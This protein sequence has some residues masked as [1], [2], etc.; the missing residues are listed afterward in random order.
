MTT[1]I[2][3]NNH[4]M[5]GTLFFRL[6]PIQ[7]LIFAMSSV[8]SIIDGAV[9]GQFIDATTVGVVGLYFPMV[10]VLTAVGNVLLGGTSV[11]C[12]R[13]MG[14]GDLK[15]TKGI[16]S[17]N[18]FLT[19]SIGLFLTLL[20]LLIPGGL[21]NMLGAS[22]Q[23]K[24]ALILYITGYAFGIVP[25]LLAQQLASFLQLERQNKRSYIG[26]GAMIISNTI[27][28]IVLVAYL[29]MGIFGLA[30]ATTASNWIYCLVLGQYYL[31]KKAQLRFDRKLIDFKEV[32]P[33]LAIGIPGA[34]L[35]VCLA[36]RSLVINRLL[37]AYAGHDGL[38]AMS[39]YNMVSGLFIAYCL[40]VGAVVRMLTSIFIGEGDRYSIKHLM[41]IVFTQGLFV[42]ILIAIVIVLCSG[43]ITQIFFPDT[44]SNVYAITKQLVIIYGSVIPIILIC[45]VFTNYLQAHEHNI[46]VNILSIFDGFLSMVIPAVL[47]A[48]VLGVLGIW[49]AG[50]IGIVMTALLTPLY[51]IYY[52]KR[53]PRNIDE[54]LFF[55]PDF[56]AKEEDRLDVRITTLEEVTNTARQVQDFCD[57][58][59]LSPKLSYYAALC[60]EEMAANVVDHGFHKDDKPHVVDA[61]VVY[62]EKS[63]LLRIKDD[64]IPFN[65]QERA[66]L[67]QSDDPLKNIGIRMVLKLADEVSYHNLL[68]LN[69]STLVLKEK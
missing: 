69:V 7:V 58:H 39:A 4:D 66:N 57:K 37:I 10:N 51:C 21:A 12:G 27:A 19:I 50:P 68:G 17:L 5:I 64:C 33:L 11:L 41:K 6:L 23:L 15:R 47:L 8:N 28:D 25:Q 60:L 42:T 32:K 35:V 45:C 53:I 36:L 43:F 56:G 26:V 49:L 2:Q 38:S 63:I 62:N 46:F 67:V 18:L 59:Q 3:N 61:H 44:T 20:S 34:M 40:G 9:A 48:P 52:W 22:E 24:P 16:F 30:L 14:A 65:P 29:K 55:P 13:Y 54:W 31:T 1:T